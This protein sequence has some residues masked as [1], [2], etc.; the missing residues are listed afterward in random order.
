MKKL[1]LLKKINQPTNKL[2][3]TKII[4]ENGKIWRNRINHMQLLIHKFAFWLIYINFKMGAANQ[5]ET[6]EAREKAAD[7]IKNRYYCL[8]QSLYLGK[9]LL[10][11]GL[12]SRDWE[13]VLLFR[14][15]TKLKYLHFCKTIVM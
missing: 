2:T 8:T 1:N 5:R 3:I 6:E 11:L 14:D 7:I 9:I 4:I 10:E 13:N 12:C 15:W